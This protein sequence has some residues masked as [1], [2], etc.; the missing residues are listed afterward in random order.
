MNFEKI[1]TAYELILEN[2]QLIENELKLIFMMRLL[3]RTLFTWVLKVPVKKLLP[4]MRNC[5]SLH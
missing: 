2:I 1:E 4:T 5:V 3:N